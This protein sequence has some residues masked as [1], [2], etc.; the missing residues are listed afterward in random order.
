MNDLTVTL[1]LLIILLIQIVILFNK[2]AMII[3][4]LAFSVF[5][6]SSLTFALMGFKFLAVL[7]L[8]IYA[9]AVVVLFLISIKIIEP[10]NYEKKDKILNK[11]FPFIVSIIFSTVI[12]ILFIKTEKN[13]TII[14]ENINHLMLTDI[15]FNKNFIIVELMSLIL[16][17]AIIGTINY[18]KK[19]Q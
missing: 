6:L 10:Q 2:N 16:I 5:L 15:M 3:T 7:Y 8:I 17:T 11:L 18:L 12:L 9:G 4:I 14:Q 13:K 1:I 19:E